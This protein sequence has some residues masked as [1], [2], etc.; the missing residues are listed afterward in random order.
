ML[1]TQRVKSINWIC[2]VLVCGM[3]VAMAT[4][5]AATITTA[6]TS[7]IVNG[8]WG[9]DLPTCRV[10]SDCPAVQKLDTALMFSTVRLLEF[11]H[12]KTTLTVTHLG[13]RNAPGRRYDQAAS[14]ERERGIADGTMLGLPC[15]GTALAGDTAPIPREDGS[16]LGR[17]RDHVALGGP[18]TGRST[19]TTTATTPWYRQVA[20]LPPWPEQGKSGSA[21]GH[22]WGQ[23]ASREREQGTAD[24]TMLGLPRSGIALAGDTAPI[25]REDGSVLGRQRDHVDLGGPPGGRSTNTTTAT[26]PWYRHAESLPPWPDQGESGSALDH[27]WEQAASYEQQRGTLLF[28]TRCLPHD[29]VRIDMMLLVD[30]SWSMSSEDALWTSECPIWTATCGSGTALGPC[31]GIKSTLI[32]GLNSSVRRV[33][34]RTGQARHDEQSRTSEASGL[35]AVEVTEQL[36][37]LQRSMARNTVNLTYRL[38]GDG[39]E[40]FSLVQALLHKLTNPSDGHTVGYLPSPTSRFRPPIKGM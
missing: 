28:L 40:S 17:Q 13:E 7:R 24:G 26:N 21:L 1:R 22:R 38:D 27:P 23:A 18:P 9:C 5:A 15:S 30:N 6:R 39:S 37:S 8:C 11:N 25:P 35:G 19:S 29:A 20:S 12:G 2:T 33:D 3:I 14:R 34:T 16:V 10:N 4:I 36:Q 32:A 31:C